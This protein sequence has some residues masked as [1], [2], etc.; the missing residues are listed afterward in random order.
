MNDTVANSTV[1]DTVNDTQADGAQRGDTINVTNEPS[2]EWETRQADFAQGRDARRTLFRHPS[3]RVL[4]GVCSGI[5]DYFNW[6][7][8]LVRILWVIA[9]VV[10]AGAGGAGVWAY[11]ALW[12]LLPVGTQATG[13]LSSPAIS[14]NAR[15]LNRTGYVLI[16]LGVVLLLGR[17]GVLN[18]LWSAL[19]GVLGLVFWPALLIF[20]G[21]LLLSPEARRSWRGNA[22]GA[23]Q[24][25]R[26]RV[27]NRDWS[28]KRDWS[29]SERSFNGD[30]VRS[31]LQNFRQNLPLRRS[32]SDR[33]LLGV[34]G[35]IAQQLGIDANIVRIGWVVATFATA[36]FAALFYP[37]GLLLPQENTVT[38]ERIDTEAQDVQVIDGTVTR[39]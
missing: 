17:I 3:A 25:F 24:R 30:S 9:A 1:N 35:G 37:L 14:L 32:S 20:A 5:A 22:R 39:V 36:G 18:V 31:S 33:V 34:S 4:G 11:V 29:S 21:I 15:N 23:G 7:P 6:D 10:L 26:Q 13:Q 2:G 16:G 19:T 38:V 12:L 27:R 28:M 8:A